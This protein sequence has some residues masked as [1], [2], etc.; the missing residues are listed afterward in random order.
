MNPLYFKS[1]LLCAGG[2]LSALLI[3]SGTFGVSNEFV[4]FCLVFPKVRNMFY[5]LLC[6]AML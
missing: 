3:K 4:S 5:N 6:F 1:R 2:G